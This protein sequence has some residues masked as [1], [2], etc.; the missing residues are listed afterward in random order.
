MISFREIIKN[1]IVPKLLN[2]VRD[3]RIFNEADMQYR[4][5]HHLDKVCYPDLFLTNQP[6]IPVGQRRGKTNVKPD[7][8]VFHPKEK[9]VTA[10]ELKCF[11]GNDSP[12]FSTVVD[13]VWQDIGKL[14]GFRKRYE[15]STNAFAVVLVNVEDR[16][17]FAGFQKEFSTDREEW[18]KHYL[19]IHLVNIYC[20]E[21]GRKRRWYDDWRAEWRI[22]QKCFSDL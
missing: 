16:E 19:F 18:M 6:V 8:V 9:P 3:Y 4:A 14:Q 21:N 5:A 12:R 11:I 20:D 22:W 10:V 1:D 2:D 15:N 7:I 13:P 17:L